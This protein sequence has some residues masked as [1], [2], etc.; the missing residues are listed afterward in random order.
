MCLPVLR[1]EGSPSFRKPL[2]QC[3]LSQMRDC[4]GSCLGPL[5][6]GRDLWIWNRTIVNCESE[7]CHSDEQREEESDLAHREVF[8]E[9]QLA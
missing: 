2:Y 9:R 3:A 7:V 6:Q 8:P 5:N 4:N 1:R